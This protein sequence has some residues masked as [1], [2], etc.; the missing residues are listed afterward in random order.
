MLT[1]KKLL[2]MGICKVCHHFRTNGP[3]FWFWCLC[4]G[5]RGHSSGVY[6]GGALLAPQTPAHKVGCFN[7]VMGVFSNLK[8]MAFWKGESSACAIH[9]KV[10]SKKKGKKYPTFSLT[11]PQHMKFGGR[12]KRN[13]HGQV[14]KSIIFWPYTS[15]TKKGIFLE[16][17]PDEWP[18]GLGLDEGSWRFG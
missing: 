9:L 2:R 15:V 4:W 16:V 8:G 1:Y 17:C 11:R 13:S 10:D 12:H 6:S 14:I 18:P 7:N 3:K 5:L